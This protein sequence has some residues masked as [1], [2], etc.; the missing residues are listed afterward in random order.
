MDW[1]HWE[2]KRVSWVSHEFLNA[3]HPS[4]RFT[5]DYSL[6]QINYLDVLIIAKAQ[7][8]KIQ[9]CEIRL[10]FCRVALRNVYFQNNWGDKWTNY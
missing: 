10:I 2:T 4:I 7:S 5:V 3:F 8:T 9:L 1:Y 6:Y